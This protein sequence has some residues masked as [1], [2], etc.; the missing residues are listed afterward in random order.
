M[1]AQRPKG[2]GQA[3]RVSRVLLSPQRSSQPPLEECLRALLRWAK[4]ERSPFFIFFTTLLEAVSRMPSLSARGDRAAPR[5][6]AEGKLRAARCCACVLNQRCCCQ[7]RA[8]AGGP[9]VAA[10]KRQQEAQ[11]QNCPRHRRAEVTA[12]AR[13]H[14]ARRGVVLLCAVC[15]GACPVSARQQK[16]VSG[17]AWTASSTSLAVAMGAPAG[18]KSM[19]VGPGLSLRQKNF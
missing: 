4:Q 17:S 19:Q 10:H 9:R 5:R 16:V 8:S 11:V 12:S 7:T 1:S 15:R 3:A 6:Q 2:E 13:A 18:V 14:S